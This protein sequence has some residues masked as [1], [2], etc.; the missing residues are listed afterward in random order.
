MYRLYTEHPAL[1]LLN[2]F[3][4]VDLVLDWRSLRSLL[5]DALPGLVAVWRAVRDI[6]MTA[7]A[8]PRETSAPTPF[9]PAR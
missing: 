1:T 6:L 8:E 4:H 7:H 9:V 2:A 3:A 5:R